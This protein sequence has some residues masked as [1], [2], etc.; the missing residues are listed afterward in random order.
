MEKK[1]MPKKKGLEQEAIQWPLQSQ[2]SY[3][4]LLNPSVLNQSI[5]QS[6]H[7]CNQPFCI[8]GFLMLFAG[9]IDNRVPEVLFSQSY[10]QESHVLGHALPFYF[11]DSEHKLPVISVPKKKVFLRGMMKRWCW[12]HYTLHEILYCHPWDFKLI[13]SFFFKSGDLI[14]QSSKRGV[15]IIFF[16]FSYS[17]SYHQR[18][19]LESIEPP[20]S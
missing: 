12:M 14:P 5:N 15:L 18:G 2:N 4:L 6:L 13:V 20:F 16:L 11:P 10:F 19:V 1:T 8:A 7:S 9:P 17:Q 3:C